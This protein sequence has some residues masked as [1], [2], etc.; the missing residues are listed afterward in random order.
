MEL[1]LERK[2]YGGILVVALTGLAFDRL[3]LGG[4][5]TGPQSVEAAEPQPGTAPAAAA[6]P[7]SPTALL[8][9]KLDSFRA[10]LKSEAGDAFAL[11]LSLRPDAGEPLAAPALQKARTPETDMT[12]SSVGNVG[13]PGA[14]AR[15]GNH[16]LR[17][18]VEGPLGLLLV[19]LE[20]A[21]GGK[22]PM[23][24]EFVAVVRDGEGQTHT[25]RM[26]MGGRGSDQRSDKRR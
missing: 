8:T 19:S 21:D 16:L 1:S 24:Q 13:T 23:M 20:K 9:Q 6:R 12:L 17:V 5:A 7:P 22:D 10:M 25:L 2:V 4:A 18:G 15:V 3:Y 26:T 11:P 14:F